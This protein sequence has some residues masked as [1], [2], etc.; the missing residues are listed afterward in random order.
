MSDLHAQLDR[1]LVDLW[2]DLSATGNY[3]A[4]LDT[5]L[6]AYQILRGCPEGDRF[7]LQ[8]LEPLIVAAEAL[9]KQNGLNFEVGFEDPASART[10]SFCGSVADHSKLF[11]GPNV[12]ICKECVK[13]LHSQIDGEK[14]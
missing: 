11:A 8:L 2:S 14:T 6:G 7:S 1:V 4:V 10:C 3:R 9:A 5:T 12:R 13:L